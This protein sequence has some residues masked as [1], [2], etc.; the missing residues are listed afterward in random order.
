[1]LQSMPRR[2]QRRAKGE[3]L[4]AKGSEGIEQRG[5]A[6]ERRTLYDEVT[7]KIIHELEGGRFPWVQPWAKA[8]EGAN[9]AIAPGLP[10]NALSARP[11]SGVNILI[12]WSAVIEQG[13]AS[14]CWLTFRQALEAGGSVRKGERGTSIV[15]ADRFVPKTEAARAAQDGDDAKAMPFLKRFT[16][17][18]VAQC[19]GLRPGL[20][21]DPEP[22]GEREI[23]PI[24]E[25]LINA[26]GADFRI[27]GDKAYYVPSHDYI[28][29]PPQ[30]AFYDQ[31][32]FYRTALHELTIGAAIDPG[33]RGILLAAPD[34]RATRARN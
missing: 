20:A 14:Q 21:S 4:A 33:L 17:F 10:R 7:A 8:G 22:L 13:F 31:V 26:S 24:A 34:H 25:Q 16:V 2:A 29:V 32:N 5:T 1:M 3:G 28:A 30:T 23:V 19:D 6:P 11:Y 9:G 27:G 12:L 18:N 15:Y